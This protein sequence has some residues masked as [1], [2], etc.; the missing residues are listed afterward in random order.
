MFNSTTLFRERLSA[1]IKELSRYMRYILNGH[2]AIA[3]VFLISVL[4]VY[5]QAWLA[6]LPPSFPALMIIAILFGLLASYTPINTLLQEPDL[7]FI[8]V[9]E[10]KMTAYFRNA[11]IYSYVVQLY[12]VLLLVAA[13]GPL[14]F[15]AFPERNIKVYLLTLIVLLIIKALNLSIHWTMLR[16]RNANL[17]LGESVIRL[18]LTIILFVYILKADYV[19]TTILTIVL[20]TMFIV[21]YVMTR[22]SIGVN[23]ELLV[24]KDRNRKQFFYRMASM[25]VDVPHLPSKVKRRRLLTSYVNRMTPFDK[26]STYDYLYR[27]TFLRS[28][29]Y[30]QMYIRLIILGGLLIYFVPNMLLKLAFALLFIYM[31]NFQ[32]ISL[33]HH[34]RI[35]IWLDLYP[36]QYSVRIRS[37]ISLLLLLTFIQTIL[38][39]VLFLL[40]LNILYAVF[41]LIL[42]SIFNYYFNV[43]FVSRKI[44]DP[45]R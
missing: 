1:H 9:S 3:L 20:F 30:L 5:Y 28:G 40:Q 17:R 29:D 21:S 13:L 44:I 39:T 18:L 16:V 19:V 45:S 22:K 10:H 43:S 23:W 14:Y 8:I 36:V 11:L 27:Q 34:H 33:Y 38:F 42:G 41:T 6:E 32:L 2:T 24:E 7:V 25:F 26:D 12:F 4:A 35:M 31:S 37:F 15:H